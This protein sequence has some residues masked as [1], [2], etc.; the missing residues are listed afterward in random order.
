[1]VSYVWEVANAEFYR[2]PNT[3]ISFTGSSYFF[4]ISG[5]CIIVF[6][7]TINYFYFSGSGFK[8]Y[9]FGTYF[10]IGFYSTTAFLG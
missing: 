1:M 6:T 3:L 5:S 9:F 10:W 7:S 4:L 2:D 8:G